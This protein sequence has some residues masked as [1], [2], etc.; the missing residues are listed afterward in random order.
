MLPNL[1]PAI[2]HL[3]LIPPLLQRSDH[4]LYTVLRHVTPYF[5]LSATLTLYSHEVREYDHATRLFDSLLAYGPGFSV[6]LFIKVLEARKPEILELIDE[7]GAGDDVLGA[8]LGRWKGED[9]LNLEGWILGAKQLWL[10]QPIQKLPGYW[11]LGK[12]SVLRVRGSTL[13]EGERLF[14][15]QEAQVAREKIVKEVRTKAVKVWADKR[16]RSAIVIGVLSVVIGI[17]ARKGMGQGLYRHGEGIAFEVWKFVTGR[18]YW[19]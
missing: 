2:S 7:M 3:H 6:Y 11:A 10:E 13:E 17:M 1:T 5:A 12:A 16:V 8:V 18:A 14:K 9:F 15:R 19:K 4:E